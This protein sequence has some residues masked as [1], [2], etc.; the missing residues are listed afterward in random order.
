MARRTPEPHSRFRPK[1]LDRTARRLP[2]QSHPRRRLQRVDILPPSN[3][4]SSSLLSNRIPRPNK[5]CRRSSIPR[6]NPLLDK[7][8]RVTVLS[9]SSRFD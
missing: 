2:K 6:L 1:L 8:R 4:R 5:V 9:H 7:F 3:T